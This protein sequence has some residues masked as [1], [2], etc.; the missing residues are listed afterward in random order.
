ITI[1]KINE[2]VIIYQDEDLE[3]SENCIFEISINSGLITFL[4][5]LFS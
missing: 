4:R 2:Y 3:K 5:F 1:I